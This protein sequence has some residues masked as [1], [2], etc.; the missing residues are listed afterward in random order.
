MNDSV[1]NIKKMMGIINEWT[2]RCLKLQEAEDEEL[3]ELNNR[4]LFLPDKKD[5]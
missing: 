3:K 5:D 4:H 2:A 1:R